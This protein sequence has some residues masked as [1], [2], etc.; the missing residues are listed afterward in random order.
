MEVQKE[1]E[2]ITDNGKA[3]VKQE[4]DTKQRGQEK[5]AR[6]VSVERE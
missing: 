5:E 3:E 6:V 4:I 1:L 2:K